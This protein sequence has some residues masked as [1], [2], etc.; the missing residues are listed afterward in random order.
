MLVLFLFRF[1]VLRQNVFPIVI[2]YTDHW[3]NSLKHHQTLRTEW[4]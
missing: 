2:V 3:R 1:L 4:P